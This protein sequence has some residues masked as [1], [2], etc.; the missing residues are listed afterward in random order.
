M[1]G[2]EVL[3]GIQEVDEVFGWPKPVVIAVPGD[4]VVVLGH[5]P[6]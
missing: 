5:D 3:S 6:F 1:K 2:A 4:E